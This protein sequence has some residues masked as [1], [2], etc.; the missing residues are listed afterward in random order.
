MRAEHARRGDRAVEVIADVIVAG[1]GVPQEWQQLRVSDDRVPGFHEGLCSRLPV[2]RDLLLHPHASVAVFKIV[3]LVMR[4]RRA[5]PCLEIR[6]VVVLGDHHETLPQFNACLWQ[7]QVFA[8]QMLEIPL[9]R[10]FLEGAVVAPG[11]AVERAAQLDRWA[12][13]GAQLAPAVEAGVVEGANRSVFLAD[14]QEALARDLEHD[15]IAGVGHFVLARGE[16]PHVGPHLLAFKA[17]EVFG[18]IGLHRDRIV[19]H[20]D[21]RFLEQVIGRCARIAVQHVGVADPGATILPVDVLDI[22]HGLPLSIPYSHFVQCS[23]W[24]ISHRLRAGSPYRIGEDR[25]RCRGKLPLWAR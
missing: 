21:G 3:P 18:N 20:F 25:W 15:C 1:V 19:A 23:V 13:G 12:A 7:R 24:R 8:L 2:R 11:E 22:V 5:E 9:R 4:R 17:G 10:D 14:Q 6:Q 16:Q